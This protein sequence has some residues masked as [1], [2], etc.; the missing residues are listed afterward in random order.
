MNALICENT[1]INP[2]T[3]PDEDNW[4]EVYAMTEWII[5]KNSG[6]FNKK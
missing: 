1:H 6:E 5:R 4:I 2:L 3:I